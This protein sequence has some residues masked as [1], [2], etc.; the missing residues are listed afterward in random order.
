M[1]GKFHSSIVSWEL[2]LGTFFIPRSHEASPKT[3]KRHIEPH[4]PSGY[5]WSLNMVSLS[6]KTVFRAQEFPL[7]TAWI[8]NPIWECSWNV[9]SNLS[10]HPH[11]RIVERAYWGSN[12]NFQFFETS[13][14][15]SKIKNWR[16]IIVFCLPYHHWLTN[17][18]FSSLM[19]FNFSLWRMLSILAPAS[20]NFKRENI[21][22]HRSSKEFPFMFEADA[23]SVL[24]IITVHE[25]NE[26]IFHFNQ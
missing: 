19:E 4:N 16:Q 21:S 15:R 8:D 20:R 24:S 18:I 9:F 10:F 13:F 12:Q 1:Q 2:F 22:R 23:A 26:N 17:L 14:H 25:Y 7:C 11:A 6:L 5:V 3:I